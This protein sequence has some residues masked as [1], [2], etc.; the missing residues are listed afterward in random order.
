MFLKDPR[1]LPLWC[2]Q[3]GSKIPIAHKIGF[4][5]F[6][7]IGIG[8]L[9]SM[10]GLVIADYYQGQGVKQLADAQK[11][12]QILD[13]FLSSSERLKI[14]SLRLINALE[15]DQQ[16]NLEKEQIKL[17]LEK[18]KKINLEM[19]Q[20]IAS[21]PAWLAAEPSHLEN[22][23]S[24]YTVNLETYT[25]H[26]GDELK[27]SDRELLES[28]DIQLLKKQLL[29]IM[30]GE[31]VVEQEYLHEQLLHI[32]EIAQNQEQ[33]G[34]VVMEEAQGLEKL[35]IVLSALLSVVIA[36]VIALRTTNAIARPLEEVTSI[37]QRV[38]TESNFDLR[39]KSMSDDEIGALAN[40]L[41]QLIQWVGSYINQLEIARETLEQRVKDRT[42]DLEKSNHK[43]QQT[44]QELRKTQSQIIHSEKM[45]SLGQMVAGVAHEI[46]NP[47]SFIYSNIQPAQE[48]AQDFLELLELYQQY[49]P[50]PPIEI[51]EEIETID[52][53]FLKQDFPQLLNSMEIGA[54]RIRE[55][56]NSLRTFSRLDQAQL[57]K[58][59]IHDGIDSTLMILAHRF[60]TTSHNS[61]IKILKNYGKL[62]LVTCYAG[63]LN[64]VFMNILSNA[65]DAIEEKN[66]SEKLHLNDERK[67]PMWFDNPYIEISTELKNTDFIA[68]KITD[69]GSGIK[70]KVRSQLFDPFFTTKAVGK[71]TGLGLS[72]S[73]Q[74]I[75]EKHSGK[76]SYQ[77]YPGEYTQFVI[78]IPIQQSQTESL[79]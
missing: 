3:F 27:N 40:S 77:S 32:I 58:V 19:K 73:Y 54:E 72:I 55:I 34:G 38:T 51:Q 42:L 78:E 46:N 60:K 64:Q 24:K 53:D 21:K 22:L 44:L 62:P 16:I 35:I 33:K 37:A 29:D 10:T 43:L 8:F 15:N 9:G 14:H 18:T 1:E 23:L 20:F 66:S 71:G 65:I 69:N 68:I 13:S 30:Q 17:N 59:D 74:I 57:K 36:G 63:Q 5:Y 25:K 4:G 70:A 31:K 41:N 26:I 45:S 50:Q 11:Q 49:Y 75:V 39:V 48:Y 67:T 6:I 79:T 47:V 12:S 28:K 7:A 56:V 2:K 61:A 52:L 76:L